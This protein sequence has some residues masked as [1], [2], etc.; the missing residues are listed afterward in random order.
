M[1]QPPTYAWRCGSSAWRDNKYNKSTSNAEEEDDDEPELYNNKV[2]NTLCAQCQ[3]VQPKISTN[4]RK[5]IIICFTLQ[6][7]SSYFPVM[8]SKHTSLL[9]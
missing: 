8:T 2:K 9:L 1:E 5:N 6:L 3:T 7:K 4:G